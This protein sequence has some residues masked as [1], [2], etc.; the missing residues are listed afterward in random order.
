MGA[1][2]GQRAVVFGGSSGAGFA[3]AQA[4]IA[5]GARVVITARDGASVKDAAMRLGAGAEGQVVDGTDAAATAAFF[6][7]VGEI[8]HLAITAG[9]TTPGGPFA[10]MTMDAFR[11]PFEGK[12]WVQMNAAHAGARRVRR[13]GSIT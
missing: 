13:G 8:D 7:Q 5:D 6:E 9:S 2:T 3:A 12:F 10:T 1:L 11:A 4:F